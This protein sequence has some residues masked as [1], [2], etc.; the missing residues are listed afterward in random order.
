MDAA[1]L[2]FAGIYRQA[3]LLRSREVSS[4]TLVTLYL[5]RIERLGSKLN[6]FRVVFADRALAE[7]EEADRRIAAGES[8]PLLGVPIAVKDNVD[9]VAEL[10]TNGTAAYEQPAEAD[11]AVYRRLRDAGA[12]LIGKTNLPELAIWPFTETEAWGTTRNPWNTGHSSGGSS[13]GS[14]AAV[15][16]GLI[17]AASASDGG[18]SIR[19]PASHCGLFGLKPQRG[20][21][22]LQPDAEHWLGLSVTGCVSRRVIDTALWLDVT[23]GA[24]PGDADTPP[25]PDKPYVD[26]ARTSPGKLRVAM[27][28]T[29]PRPAAPPIITDEVKAGV[30]RLGEIL[31]SLGHTV[32]ER[33]PD[34]GHM[35]NDIT[36][37]YLGGIADDGR[38]VPHPDLLEKR[39]R[40]MIRL[41]GLLPDSAVRRSRSNEAKHAERLNRIFDDFDVVLTPVVGIPPPEAGRWAGK[42]A[43][44]TLMSVSRAYPCAIAWNYTGQPAA[45]IPLPPAEPG[46]LPLS[47]Q[48]IVPPNREDL[49]I[50]LG[51]QLETEIGWPDH[52][53]EEFA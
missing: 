52:V 23:A 33:D 5:E 39:T 28:V 43:L 29:A 40:G 26:A 32:T 46:G 24:E 11:S 10:T 38:H 20:R 9:V 21:V 15:A 7:A 3:E 34:W 41:G 13:G 31:E 50:S 47:G 30:A 6:A 45:S 14:G 16:A 8:A 44:R 4:R 51:A 37:R 49:L 53:P 22:S 1:E 48:L 35:G 27:S 2:A 12:V 36:S 18:G 19:I 25:P 42:G 17:G